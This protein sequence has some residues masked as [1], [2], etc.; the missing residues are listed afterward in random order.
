MQ[1]YIKH[2]IN[3][4][5]VFRKIKKHVLRQG[6]F[7]FQKSCYFLSLMKLYF[8]FPNDAVSGLDQ[9]AE[10]PYVILSK[11]SDGMQLRE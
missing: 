10:P 5:H 6:P 7:R 11:E 2:H 3:E 8:S 4:L 9:A 1:G